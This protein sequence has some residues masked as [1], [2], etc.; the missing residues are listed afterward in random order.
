MFFRGLGSDGSCQVILG[1]SLGCRLLWAPVAG[2]GSSECEVSSVRGHRRRQVVQPWQQG[3][4]WLSSWSGWD[5]E[6]TGLD[7]EKGQII[8]VAC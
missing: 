7:M 2:T 8:E 3:S 4:T 6:K 1:M 5:P